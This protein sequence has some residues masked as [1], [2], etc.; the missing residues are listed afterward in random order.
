M[1][2]EGKGEEE[3]FDEI[4]T[5]QDILEEQEELT[6]DADAGKPPVTQ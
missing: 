1:S 5:M 3:D 2:A 6:R 4:V